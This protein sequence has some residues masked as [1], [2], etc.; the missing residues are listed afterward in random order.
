VSRATEDKIAGIAVVSL[1]LLS[2]F[3]LI[4]GVLVSK[5]GANPGAIVAIATGAVGGI[6]AIVLQILRRENGG[7][8]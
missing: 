8:E 7:K 2:A 5:W 1:A 6:V 4:A 3:A